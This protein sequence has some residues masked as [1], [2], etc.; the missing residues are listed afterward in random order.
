[1]KRILRREPIYY[2]W[3]IALALAITT[4]VSFGVLFYAFSV[5]IAPMEAEFG[6]SRGE[7]SGGL[8]SSRFS[9]AD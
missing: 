8:F 6:W 9:S 5:F 1:M 2:G 4:T 3:Y 7:L